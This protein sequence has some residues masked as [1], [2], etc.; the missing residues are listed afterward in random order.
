[1]SSNEEP[2][3]VKRFR[4]FLRINTEQPNPEYCIYFFQGTNKCL[5]SDKCRDFLFEYAKELG[6]SPWEYE[7]VKLI[8]D[9]E[10]YI[11]N[12]SVFRANHWLE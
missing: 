6:F 9:N 7:V 11:L 12:K 5:N 1:M 4:D 2:I 3:S 8:T 10:D